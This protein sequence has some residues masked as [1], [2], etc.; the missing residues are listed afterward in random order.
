MTVPRGS[1]P[2]NVVGLFHGGV[3]VSDLDRSVAFY[4]DVLG[5]EVAIRRDATEEYLREMHGQP[6]T[7]VRMAFLAIPNS[8]SMIELIEYQGVE[9]R[10]PTYQPSDPSTGHLCFL[11]DDIHAVDARLRSAGCPGRSADP[12]E[13][14]AGPNKG[15]WAVYFADPDGYPIEFIQRARA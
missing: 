1:R 3:T 12:I 7:M 2:G 8:D 13:I 4:R 14:T 15:G 10:K 11:V 6:F 9:T 5:F